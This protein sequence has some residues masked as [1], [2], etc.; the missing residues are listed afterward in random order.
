[1]HYVGIPGAIEQWIKGK[2]KVGKESSAVG[3]DGSDGSVGL[4][5]PHERD[6]GGSLNKANQL[7]V[8]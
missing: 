8:A 7:K 5:T 2:S 1:M 4:E 6:N 3:S